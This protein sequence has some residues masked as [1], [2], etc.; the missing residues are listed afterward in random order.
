MLLREEHNAQ[1]EAGPSPWAGRQCSAPQRSVAGSAVA[2]I[3]SRPSRHTVVVSNSC[4]TPARF[5]CSAETTI[6]V[7]L[8][9][10]PPRTRPT[11]FS[12]FLGLERD[13]LLD[14]PAADWTDPQSKLERRD[15]ILFCL[16][17]LALGVLQTGSRGGLHAN[18]DAG[19]DGGG[20]VCQTMRDRGSGDAGAGRRALARSRGATD[21]RSRV[22]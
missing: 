1:S 5:A 16:V 6:S 8:I 2:H 9:S 4:A 18:A 17:N 19:R 11:H 15:A 3:H 20:V 7:H 14:L 12:W 21:Q 10:A 13:G 22:A